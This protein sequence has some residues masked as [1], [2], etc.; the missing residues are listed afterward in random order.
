MYI[1]STE[2]GKDHNG[3]EFFETLGVSFVGDGGEYDVE[4]ILGTNESISDNLKL[5]YGG[6]S[7]PHY[8]VDQLGSTSAEMLF[9]CETDHGR[10]FMNNTEN[11]KVVASS[12]VIGAVANGDSMNLKPY[13]FSEMV[14]HFIAYDPFV[15]V[16]ENLA[17]PFKSKNFPNPFTYS[18]TINYTVNETNIVIIE[19]YNAS[20]QMIRQ[21]LNRELTAGEYSVCWDGSNNHGEHAKGGFYFYQISVGDKT[22]T[23]KMVLLR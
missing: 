11:Y 19:V 22:Q 8:S 20:G 23:D 16:H 6:G 5:Y 10:M 2:L 17:D 3:T 4:K 14:N 7:S 18:T 15:S 1:E 12:V 13:I 9:C 21:L